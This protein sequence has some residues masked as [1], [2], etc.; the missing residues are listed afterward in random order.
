MA[1][2]EILRTPSTA[3][4]FAR[5]NSV[6]EFLSFL[7]SMRERV[8]Q[9]KSSVVSAE[10]DLIRA[11]I[12][13]HYVDNQGKP[14][15][16]QRFESALYDDAPTMLALWRSFE[17]YDTADLQ[18]FKRLTKLELDGLKGD[19]HP[20][21]IFDRSPFGV[22][23]LIVGSV[24]IWMSVLK[25]YSGQNLGELL[26]LLEAIRFNWIV[27]TMWVVG[28]FV[29]VWYIIKTHRNNS[30]VAFLSSVSRALDVYLDAA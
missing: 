25:T 2:A 4:A 28:L 10:L 16:Y 12:E 24:T 20:R 18:L 5:A 21:K 23:A 26:L 15:M 1:N 7:Q 6:G 14:A 30:Q 3:D 27:G 9:C 8:K 22:V 17:E 13:E 19:R 11:P 29:V